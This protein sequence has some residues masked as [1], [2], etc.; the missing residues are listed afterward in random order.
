M[1]LN[2]RIGGE[3]PRSKARRI[4]IPK[5]R[6]VPDG[7]LC[8]KRL[9]LD[10]EQRSLCKIQRE[11]HGPNGHF[12]RESG[13]PQDSS[14]GLCPRIRRPLLNKSFAV[15]TNQNTKQPQPP[16]QHPTVLR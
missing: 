12:I 4:R 14:D 3:V 1:S 6:Q 13:P 11:G 15:W 5:R 16:T 7:L 9:R 10:G 2:Y 8:A